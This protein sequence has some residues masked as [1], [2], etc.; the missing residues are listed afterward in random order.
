MSVAHLN[1][2]IMID[3]DHVTSSIWQKKVIPNLQLIKHVLQQ[4]QSPSQHLGIITMPRRYR[5]L[6]F[7]DED[8]DAADMLPSRI[9]PKLPQTE[10]QFRL[11]NLQDD[12]ELLVMVI[13][14]VMDVLAKIVIHAGNEQVVINTSQR[15]IKLYMY[16]LIRSFQFKITASTTQWTTSTHVKLKS[17]TS[18]QRHI[19]KS[20]L[21][22]VMQ[23]SESQ[24]AMIPILESIM[25]QSPKSSSFKLIQVNVNTN[26]LQLIRD[27]PSHVTPLTFDPTMPYNTTAQDM[28]TR[29]SEIQAYVNGATV[30]KSKSPIISTLIQLKRSLP[31]VTSVTSAIMSPLI[32]R[33][34]DINLQLSKLSLPPNYNGTVNDLGNRMGSKAYEQYQASKFKLNA[35]YIKVLDTMTSLIGSLQVA[36]GVKSDKSAQAFVKV[37]VHDAPALLKVFQVLGYDVSAIVGDTQNYTAMLRRLMS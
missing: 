5:S 34:I 9:Y 33:W 13:V 35:Q 17:S 30:A 36:D 15:W 20:S 12:L 22:Y 24:S 32:L 26:Q 6:D 8:T 37:S 16:L 4:H 23:L 2:S 21:F 29:P 28:G 31:L 14:V 7:Y 1:N 27:I 25:L 11:A 3:N 18:I 19:T 10:M